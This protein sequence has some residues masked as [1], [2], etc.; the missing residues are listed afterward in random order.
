[1]KAGRMVTGTGH[2]ALLGEP[3][4]PGGAG[5]RGRQPRLDIKNGVKITAPRAI[6]L[7][8]DIFPLLLR[9]EPAETRR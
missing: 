9:N 3:P 7:F 2:I 6:K 8:C 4:D 5:W 1:M